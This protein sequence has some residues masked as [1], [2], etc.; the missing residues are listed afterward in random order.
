[1]ILFLSAPMVFAVLHLFGLHLFLA[2]IAYGLQNQ[3]EFF[4]SHHLLSEVKQS[5]VCGNSFKLEPDVT[6]FKSVNLYHLL[7]VSAGNLI[8]WSSAIKILFWA[9]RIQASVLS[10]ALKITLLG[11]LSL[12]VGFAPPIATAY[13]CKVGVPLLYKGGKSSSLNLCLSI[14]CLIMLFP[15]WLDS[16]SFYLSCWCLAV[17]GFASNLHRG[18]SM[19]HLL[20]RLF[21]IQWCVALILGN[22]NPISLFANFILAPAISFFLIPLAYLSVLHHEIDK[23]FVFT[24]Q[25]FIQ[26]LSVITLEAPRVTLFS[27]NLFHWLILIG[28]LTLARNF[29]I[30]QTRQWL[31]CENS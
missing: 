26:A 23:F 24:Y 13:F 10:Q 17:L 19:K 28:F 29:E 1:M 3:C 5:L 22:F 16:L 15:H 27:P 12:S 6:L 2:K 21:L 9:A 30:Y 4:L 14:A 7:V 11:F 20:L 18:F 31:L 25:S 8:L